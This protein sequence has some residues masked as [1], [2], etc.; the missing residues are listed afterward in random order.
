MYWVF[1]RA[2]GRAV[3]FSNRLVWRRYKRCRSCAPYFGVA[4]RS[5]VRVAYALLAAQ[6]SRVRA[7]FCTLLEVPNISC[8]L[9]LLSCLEW[10]G[11]T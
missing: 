2:G 3:T 8:V 5:R 11:C 1:I 7:Y 10:I 9:L 6:Q 4:C